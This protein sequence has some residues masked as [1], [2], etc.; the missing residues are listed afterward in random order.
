[1]IS[2]S[3]TVGHILLAGCILI[4]VLGYPGNTLYAQSYNDLDSLS[5]RLDS[6]AMLFLSKAPEFDHDISD[7]APDLF[8]DSTMTY[9]DLNQTEIDL[10]KTRQEVLN[11]D[12][13]I[14][15]EAG[16]LQN[17]DQGVFGAEGIFYQRRAQ[18]GVQWNILK[19][20]F[21]D[22]KIT[23][24]ELGNEVRIQEK[25]AQAITHQ[26]DLELKINK[27]RADFNRFRVERYEAYLEILEEQKFA[28][29]RLYDQN[30]VTLD[31]VLDVNSKIVKAESAI[32]N[33]KRI[34]RFIGDTDSSG[35]GPRDYV[36]YDIDLERLG[37]QGLLFYDDLIS[38]QKETDY[39]SYNELSLSTFLRYNL[40]GGTNPEG[41]FQNTGSRE[42][43]SAG[44]SLSLP[45]PLGTGGKR[46]IHEQEEKIRVLS[47]RE[48]KSEVNRTLLEK[49]RAYQATLQNYIA[50]YQNIYLMKDKIRMQ[51]VRR[52]IGSDIYSPTE[53][54][55][56]ISDLYEVSIDILNAKEELYLRLFE[57]QSLIPDHSLSA[58]LYPYAVSETNYTSKPDRGMYIW[59]GSIERHSTAA[60]LEDLQGVETLYLSAGAERESVD[61]I[62]DIIKTDANDHD[63]YMM[64]GDPNL[65]FEDRYEKLND[66]VML[67]DSIGAGGVHLD[68]EPHTLNDWE[69]NSEEYLQAYINMVEQ[70]S[71]WTDEKGLKLSVSVTGDYV[72]IYRVLESLADNIVLMIYGV[73]DFD[74]F[75]QRYG[76]VIMEAPLGASIALR[77]DDFDSYSSLEELM[78]N[79]KEGFGTGEFFIQDFG[80]W[81]QLKNN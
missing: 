6:V 77:A 5:S 17:L 80:T 21:F 71:E 47:L 68:V 61:R 22:N 51:R 48:E 30:Y 24:E 59:S 16:L 65:I 13:G 72:S 28:L 40:Y 60:L 45:I 33:S 9:S 49:Y 38:L 76:E 43:F 56:A 8:Y 41:A 26:A 27:L 20:G 50:V 69:D 74:S 42:F 4:L 39:K 78:M 67:A 3:N 12:H 75:S 2:H 29:T 46:K 18:V 32:D 25:R 44:V 11:S 34:M 36:V 15:L 58:Y 19:N 70:V 57:M 66:F 1:L 53:L 14:D 73:N 81:I 62:Q 64:I 35:L 63:V 52:T 23:I 10:L 31:K 54:L 7:Q 37:S 55:N 79:V